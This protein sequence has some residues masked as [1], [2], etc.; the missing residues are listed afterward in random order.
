MGYPTLTYAI[1]GDPDY[2]DYIDSPEGQYA[3]HTGTTHMG[4]GSEGVNWAHLAWV[5]K[6][7]TQQGL[8]DVVYFFTEVLNAALGALAMPDLARR[9]LANP[10]INKFNIHVA[11]DSDGKEWNSKLFPTQ[12]YSYVDGAKLMIVL[13]VG[14][15]ALSTLTGFAPKAIGPMLAAKSSMKTASHRKAVLDGLDD[16]RGKSSDRSFEIKTPL[17][18]SPDTTGIKHYTTALAEALF[19][20]DRSRLAKI[21]QHGRRE[22]GTDRMHQ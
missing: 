21:V 18:T 16:I 12:D 4:G 10:Q 11:T 15:A 20:D 22:T 17:I 14:T 8:S 7:K 19:H 1:P 2:G 6:H 13:L 5:G 9:N 3:S